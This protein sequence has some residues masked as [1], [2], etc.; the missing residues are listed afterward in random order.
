MT[1]TRNH[2]RKNE[3]GEILRLS[4][5]HG[6][7]FRESLGLRFEGGGTVKHSQNPHP[8]TAA[9]NQSL[10]Y[11]EYQDGNPETRWGRREGGIN[12]GEMKGGRG[13]GG[14]DF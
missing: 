12:A 10:S 9:K 14:R 2:Q 8:T 1:L 13:V 4:G 11:L 6:T 7:A 5:S 3:V